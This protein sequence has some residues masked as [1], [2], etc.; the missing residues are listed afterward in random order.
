M[1]ALT[2]IYD[3]VGT[4]EEA[5]EGLQANERRDV[6]E[7]PHRTLLAACTVHCRAFT[8]QVAPEYRARRL[9]E[10]RY[11]WAHGRGKRFRSEPRS[12]VRDVL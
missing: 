3:T 7:H 5:V 1:P 4:G 2:D 11:F 6:E 9:D 10:R 8:G 12:K